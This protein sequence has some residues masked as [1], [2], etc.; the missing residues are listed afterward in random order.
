VGRRWPGG[1]TRGGFDRSGLVQ[2][3]TAQTTGQVVP[4]TTYDLIKMGTRVNPADAQ[5]GD[6]VFSEFSGRGPE[7]VQ[8][9]LGGGKVVH[10]P[11]TGDV[12]RIAA[13]PQTAIVKRIF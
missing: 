3:A 12:V 10:A 5:P 2:W 7:H 1:P 4:R 6:L 13:I 8:I 9:A 11:Q